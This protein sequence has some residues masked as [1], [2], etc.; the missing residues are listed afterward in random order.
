VGKQRQIEPVTIGGVAKR[1]LLAT[2]P[3]KARYPLRIAPERPLL[4]FA[5]GMLPEAPD[6]G[7]SDGVAFEIEVETADGT[8]SVYRR[9]VIPKSAAQQW[10][11][12]SV[13]LSRFAGQE[14]TLAF[15]TRS[16]KSEENDA[17]VWAE[18]RMATPSG[19]ASSQYTPV[20]DDEVQIFENHHALPRAFLVPHV[21]SVAD[22]GGAIAVMKEAGFDPRQ[23]AV[24]EG[25]PEREIA[26][27]GAGG[28]TATVAAYSA[29]QVSIDV[30]ARNPSLLVLTDAVY[31]GWRASID[32]Q[33]API[34]AADAAFRG[35]FVPAGEHRV[36]FTYAPASFRAGVGIALLGF[37]GL[38][39]GATGVTSRRWLSRASAAQ[40]APERVF[41]AS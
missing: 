5:M 17:A 40:P 24:V 31:P 19:E 26:A 18:V 38:V 27:L 2:P 21:V 8:E 36:E 3:D 25:A 9:K 32:G 16:L 34:Y 6:A 11:E 15:V 28:G 13:D 1:A 10:I 29:Q 37:A 4:R 39:V 22:M 41:G 23:T 30:D 12:D 35:I 14:V 7:K 20:Y 33:E